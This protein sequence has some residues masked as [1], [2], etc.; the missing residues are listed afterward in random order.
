MG[1]GP[2]TPESAETLAEDAAFLSQFQPGIGAAFFGASPSASA[3]VNTAGLQ[4]LADWCATNKVTGYMAAGTYQINDTLDLQKVPRYGLVGQGIGIT[5][6]EQTTNNI[7]VI[8]IGAVGA[9][10]ANSIQVSGMT[11]RHS[12]NQAAA[13][14]S[15]IGIKFSAEVYFGTFTNLFFERSAYGMYCGAN[16]TPWATTFDNLDFGGDISVA[17]VDFSSATTAGPNQRWGRVGVNF[18]S[19]TGNAMNMF[20]ST[21]T[22]E[23]IEFFCTPGSA[24]PARL[25]KL[26]QGYCSVGAMSVENGVWGSGAILFD[27]LAAQLTVDQFRIFS[28]TLTGTPNPVYLF[29]G[30]AGG[31]QGHIEVRK[32]SAAAASITGEG[33]CAQL[34]LSAPAT[35]RVGTILLSNGWTL[36]ST[37]Y[38]TSA[39]RCHVAE[40]ANGQLAANKGDASYAFAVGDPTIVPFNTTFTAQRTVTLPANASNNLFSGL[41]VKIITDG[42]VNGANTLVIKDGSTTLRTETNDKR[43]LT[44]TYRRNAWVLTGYETLP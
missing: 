21:I 2:I 20:G 15:A 27:V 25:F 5:I 43:A 10:E 42:A 14:T 22:I 1:V 38:S 13:N 37:G 32:L 4:A 26:N 31:A 36:Q 19:M 11:I 39:A 7:P 3:A 44:Y 40:W 12:T 18:T 34:D 24:G 30:G 6:L 28:V 16:G 9:S 35:F 29:R 23:N 41:A 17:A 8:E 33:V